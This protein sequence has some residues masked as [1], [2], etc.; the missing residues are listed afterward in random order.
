MI[1]EFD[2]SKSQSNKEKHGI[3]F[4]EAQILWE[5]EFYIE[6]ATRSDIENRFIVI[7]KIGEKHYS[8]CIT[9]RKEAV[10]IISVR[11]AREKEVALYESRRV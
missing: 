2:S 5:D 11:R 7:G 6:L 9:Y 4:I 3:D 1:F 10:R 8:A